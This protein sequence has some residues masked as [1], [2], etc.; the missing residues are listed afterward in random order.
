MTAPFSGGFSALNNLEGLYVEQQIRRG[1]TTPS[2]RMS[3]KDKSIANEIDTL[4]REL[5]SLKAEFNAEEGRHLPLAA[6]LPLAALHTYMAMIRVKM[7]LCLTGG[8]TSLTPMV[9]TC[10]HHV[11]MGC[12]RRA[13]SDP[14]GSWRSPKSAITWTWRT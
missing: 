3:E 2:S 8:P 12:M 4:E 9:H 11:Q 13:Y 10:T 6:F 14:L 7:S 1:G 5:Q